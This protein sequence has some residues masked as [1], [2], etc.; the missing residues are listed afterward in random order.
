MKSIE[1]TNTGE[2]PVEK[3][4]F[5]NPT[6]SIYSEGGMGGLCQHFRGNHAF[7]F[8]VREEKCWRDVDAVTQNRLS[9]TDFCQK[10]REF[11]TFSKLADVT[12]EP[13]PVRRI[14]DGFRIR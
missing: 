6:R 10:T 5:C 7:V 1:I 14:R 4:R 13:T 9:K 12:L 11:L 3:H 8:V 2:S